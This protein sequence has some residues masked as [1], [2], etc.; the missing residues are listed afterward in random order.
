MS[1]SMRRACEA[2]EA[3]LDDR[4]ERG[5]I[6]AKQHREMVRE[7]WRDY[8]QAAEEAARNERDRW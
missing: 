6:S 1:D 5:E 2:Y 7:I 8:R 3:E 4:L